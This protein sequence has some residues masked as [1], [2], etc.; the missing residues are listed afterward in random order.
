MVTIVERPEQRFVL[1]IVHLD[2]FGE[3]AYRRFGK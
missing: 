3:E 1:K 2:M